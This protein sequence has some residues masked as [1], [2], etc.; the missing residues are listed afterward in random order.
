VVWVT[1]TSTEG[2]GRRG[3]HNGLVAESTAGSG[4]EI[5]EH[6]ADIGLRAT[7]RSLSELFA[8][9]CHGT[10]EIMGA[11]GADGDEV[12]TVTVEAG[13]EGSLLVD[14]LNELIYLVDARQA[15]VAAAEVATGQPGRAMATFRWAPSDEELSGTELKATTYHQLSVERTEDGYTATVYFDV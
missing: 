15:R 8:N 9:A 6:T 5:L 1:P 7:G 14:V 13:D 4:Y 10:L 3:H 12:A 11:A 2:T